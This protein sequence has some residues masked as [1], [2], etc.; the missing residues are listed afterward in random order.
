M[1]PTP[2]TLKAPI[3]RILCILL[4]G[5]HW[6]QPRIGHEDEHIPGAEVANVGNSNQPFVYRVRQTG[7]ACTEAQS[8]AEKARR[9]E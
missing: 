1:S 5:F 8:E 2:N 3:I 7:P 9:G 6:A 4:E